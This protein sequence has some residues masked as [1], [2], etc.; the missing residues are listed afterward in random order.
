[1][2]EDIKIPEK[3]ENP[4]TFIPNNVVQPV[5]IE[6]YECPSCRYKIL[7]KPE[8]FDYKKL[9]DDQLI[10]T[11]EIVKN[12]ELFL[13]E[14]A[15]KNADAAILVEMKRAEMKSLISELRRMANKIKNKD[16]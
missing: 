3:Y 7:I 12:Y 11:R 15:S 1:L 10:I 2:K 16:I 13:E 8:H 9:Y 5:L 6:Y 4:F 14:I